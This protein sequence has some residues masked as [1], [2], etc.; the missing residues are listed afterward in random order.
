MLLDFH[1]A[2]NC[3]VKQMF[4]VGLFT[5][6]VCTST[7]GKVA[8]PGQCHKLSPSPHWKAKRT[9]LR[10]SKENIYC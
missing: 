7:R 3:P 10:H 8:T 4:V 1:D 6:P 5:I 9:N 2:L